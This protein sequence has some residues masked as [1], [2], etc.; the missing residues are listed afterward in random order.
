MKSLPNIEPSAFHKGEYVGYAD[1]VWKIT[2]YGY[3]W[4]A[5]HRDA[6]RYAQQ[7]RTLEE[8]SAQLER[9]TRS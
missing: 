4:R 8:L 1:G 5:V 2:R 7:G 6:S 9:I 3:G